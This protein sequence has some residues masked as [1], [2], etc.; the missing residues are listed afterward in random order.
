MS[1]RGLPQGVALERVSDAFR[2]WDV[3]R[4]SKREKAETH[5][6]TFWWFL[7]AFSDARDAVATMKEIDGHAV[8]FDLSRRKGR[9]RKTTGE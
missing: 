8:S 5:T 3:E 4:V 6:M 1:V 7:S 9:R 2:R